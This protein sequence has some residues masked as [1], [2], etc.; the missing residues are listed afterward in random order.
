LL[1]LLSWDEQTFLDNLQGS[2]IRRIGH[3]QWTRN[4]II[5]MGNAP[6][7]HTIVEA[8]TSLQ[9]SDD[10]W[11]AHISW[12]LEQQHSQVELANKQQ[13]LIRIVEKGLPRDA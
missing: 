4:L 11:D 12:A 13:R 10:L 6:Y 1:T 2:P 3:R 8:L 5:A 7:S 9:G